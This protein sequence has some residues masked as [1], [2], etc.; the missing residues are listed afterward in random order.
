MIIPKP[1]RFT[2]APGTFAFRPNVAVVPAFHADPACAWFVADELSQKIRVATGCFVTNRAGNHGQAAAPGSVVLTD[3]GAPSDLGQEGYRIEITPERVTLRAAAPAGLFYA[4]QSFAQLIQGHAAANGDTGRLTELPC[5]QV[6]DKPRFGWR[7]LMLDSARHYQPIEQIIRLI[8]RL[9]ALK[10]NRLHWHLT[11]D[12]GWRLEILGYPKLTGVGAWRNNGKGRYGGFYTQEQV[13]DIVAYARSRHIT[14]VP[15]IEMPGHNL[16]A[17]AAYP[18]LACNGAS[19]EVTGK[20]GIL[21]GV[22]CAGKEQTF[23]FLEDVLGEVAELFPGP[24]MHLGGDERKKGLWDSCPRC[25]EVRK[26]HGLAEESD[27]QKWFMQRVSGRVHESL[28]RRS[29]SWGDNIDKGGIDGQIVHG[30]LPEQT[31]KAARQGHDTINSTHEWVY[32]DYPQNAEDHADRKPDWM[33]VLPLE[34]VYA[35]DPIPQ[36]LEPQFHHHVLGSEATLWSE[37][38]PDEA[39]MYHQLFPRL[40]AFSEAVWS[41]PGVRDF[42]DFKRRLSVLQG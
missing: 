20:W 40:Y 41:D 17:L 23:R 15:E 8:D 34:K 29:I 26:A 6:Y 32:L 12:Q 11:E 4:Y 13:R 30:W 3:E 33:I 2:P 36:N 25:T 28:L 7:G 14:V 38:I 5:A 10:L 16:A 39:E 18:E 19:T 22:Y 37:Y 42:A 35:F 31:A 24:Y 21:D 27:L 1:L 9:A